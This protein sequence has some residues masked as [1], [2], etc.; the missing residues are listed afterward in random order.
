MERDIGNSGESFFEHLCHSIGITPNKV[1]IDKT[2]WDYLIEFPIELDQTKPIDLSEPTVRCYIQVKS[3]EKKR[4]GSL[5]KVSNL[6]RF[7]DTNDPC[8]FIFMDFQD[9]DRPS[10]IFVT[11]MGEVIMGKS[12]EKLRKISASGN[13]QLNRKS[14]LVSY[15][16][17]DE[18]ESVNSRCLRSKLLEFVPDGMDKY[19]D[20]KKQ[21]V[22]GLGYEDYGSKASFFINSNDIDDLTDASLQRSFELSPKEFRMWDERFGIPIERKDLANQIK[23]ILVKRLENEKYRTSFSSRR[24]TVWIEAEIFVSLF[25]KSNR[26]TKMRVFNELLDLTLA[27]DSGRA[28]MNAL[29]NSNEKMDSS[30]F[31]DFG[32]FLYILEEEGPVKFKIHHDPS[33][34]LEMDLNKA[35]I[36]PELA[37]F[38]EACLALPGLIKS[39]QLPP[40][41]SFSPEEVYRNRNKIVNAFNYVISG[42]YALIVEVLPE[43]EVKNPSNI[44]LAMFFHFTL[45][46]YSIGCKLRINGSIVPLKMK[47]VGFKSKSVQIIEPGLFDRTNGFSDRILEE[48]NSLEHEMAKSG[49]EIIKLSEPFI[50]LKL[51]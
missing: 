29:T 36:E 23:R 4:K 19:R 1:T 39:F 28:N 2:G 11:H 48:L 17:E 6:K 3:T 42:E 43:K 46:E 10:R 5:V 22:K 25:D 8:F 40:K 7:L 37:Q 24:K 13:T 27:F 32:H 14:L 34:E 21:L 15:R 47:T 44:G 41:L 16:G 45:G 35:S 20:W 38:R 31:E 50:G 9:K 49:L 26:P 51:D 18:L 30:S 33:F 12:L